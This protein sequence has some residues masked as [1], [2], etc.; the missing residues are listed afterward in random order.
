M[1]LKA[2]FL[3]PLQIYIFETYS[4]AQTT[5]FAAQ[6]AYS[7][8]KNSFSRSFNRVNF[9]VICKYVKLTKANISNK[10]DLIFIHEF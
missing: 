6:N 9:K 3:L 10:I 8:T 7:D 1:F 2:I 4:V 5:T